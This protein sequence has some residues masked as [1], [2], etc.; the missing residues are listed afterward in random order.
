MPTRIDRCTLVG[1]EST[2]RQARRALA[3][4][5]WPP[6]GDAEVVI[7]RR[8]ETRARPAALPARLYQATDR[9][10]A[11]RVDGWSP[12][13]ESADCVCFRSGAE[14]LARLSLDLAA[15]RAR[16]LWF[17]QSYRR[18]VD[19]PA[20][21]ARLWLDHAPRLPALCRVLTERRG[22]A[23][24]WRA[25]DAN[26]AAALLP[27]LA[28]AWLVADLRGQPLDA[29]AGRLLEGDRA[30]VA[31]VGAFGVAP[32][33]FA[34][35]EHA[36]ADRA[37]LALMLI[38]AGLRPHW[39]AS[40]RAVG[41]IA[42]LR[43]ALAAPDW[44]QIHGAPTSV[45]PGTGDFSRHSARAPLG[46]DTRTEVRAPRGPASAGEPG[47]AESHPPR[48]PAE[49]GAPGVAAEACAALADSDLGASGESAQAR[50][51]DAAGA[52][53]ADRPEASSTVDK[54]P[55]NEAAPA[56][57]AP[58]PTWQVDQ[59]GLFF[60]INVLNHP[61]IRARLYADA[62][63]MAFPSGWGWLLRLGE[64]V[65]LAPEPALTR[66]LVALAGPPAERFID[67][68]PPLGLAPEIVA[69]AEQRFRGQ[70]I[71]WPA[72]LTRPARL[73][74]RRPELDV[75]LRMPD[76]DLAVR[77][78]GLDIDP[79]WVEWLGTVVRFHYR[80]G[81]GWSR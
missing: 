79:G 37:L 57:S 16:G 64:A 20:G 58:E 32:A 75:S 55:D 17:W 12:A 22:L 61:V 77:R 66:C 7:L 19:D 71:G 9:L 4:C 51:R 70:G 24:L 35:A 65:G 36:D 6:V 59:G 78:V 27:R 76:L 42:P 39:L 15:G 45:G 21:L 49:A 3:T 29:A 11:T 50:T 74:Y 60:L 47:A 52:A 31:A 72:V 1:T 54:V 80:G 28:P 14:L 44:P 13:A 81:A 53:D 46:A 18:W 69:W 63:A 68:L 26:L 40:P 48:Q 34:R 8:V 67:D 23:T 41:L 43:S 33:A 5:S 30:L 38:V 2:I 10:L 25:V 62:D 73:D 56:E